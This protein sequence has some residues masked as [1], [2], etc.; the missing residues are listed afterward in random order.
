[1][2]T[3]VAVDELLATVLEDVAGL[4]DGGGAGVMVERGLTSASWSG[5]RGVCGTLL[6]SE[7]TP[8][9]LLRR[10]GAERRC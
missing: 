1:M 6:S 9:T 3:V 7:V 5:G 8:T 10:C 4:V 2:E